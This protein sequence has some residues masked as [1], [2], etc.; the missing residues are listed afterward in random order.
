MEPRLGRWPSYVAVSPA[1]PETVGVSAVW[2]E[3]ITGRSDRI[4]S[5]VSDSVMVVAE[6]LQLGDGTR[7]ESGL[8]READSVLQVCAD[9]AGGGGDCRCGDGPGCVMLPT[10]AG[11]RP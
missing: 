8:L 5:S 10:V 11:G 7:S 2:A 1:R 9:F 4:L 3:S 6:G